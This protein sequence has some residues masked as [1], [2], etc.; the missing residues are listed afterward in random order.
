MYDI[1]TTAIEG[2]SDYWL[3]CED[4]RNLQIKRNDEK[5]VI[6][7]TFESNTVGT[8]WQS[9]KIDHTSLW[10]ALE[11]ILANPMRG[12]HWKSLADSLLND[13]DDDIDFDADDADFIRQHAT[14]NE[15]VYG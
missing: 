1:L 10:K 11:E 13:E 4:I 6:E 14:F 5:D 7:V 3:M 2:G 12:I 9:H 8:T 15:Q